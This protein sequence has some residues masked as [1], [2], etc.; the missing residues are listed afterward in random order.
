MELGS[1]SN[2]VVLSI[3]GDY[4]YLFICKNKKSN[5]KHLFL[6]AE[7]ELEVIDS[8]AI[9]NGGCA[10]KCSHGN[11]GSICTCRKGYFLQ[12]DEKSCAGINNH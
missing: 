9:N 11:D 6:F 2:S 1:F 5:K 8:C 10:H 4:Q 7:I 12:A 3:K